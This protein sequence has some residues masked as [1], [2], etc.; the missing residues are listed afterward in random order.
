MMAELTVFP[1]GIPDDIDLRI[2][3]QQDTDRA[4][5]DADCLRDD[6]PASHRV[7]VVISGNLMLR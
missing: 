1:P 3:P 5:G 4:D 2:Q 6:V 7:S